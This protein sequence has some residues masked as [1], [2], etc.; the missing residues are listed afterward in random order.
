MDHQPDIEAALRYARLIIG[1]RCRNNRY[2]ERAVDLTT[3]AILAAARNFDPA[4]GSW[5]QLYGWVVNR[6]V[7][8]AISVEA[9][10]AAEEREAVSALA[11]SAE[12]DRGAVKLASPIEPEDGDGIW[13]KRQ[14]LTAKP[15]ENLWGPEDVESL[16]PPLRRAV[17]L[18]CHHG[19]SVV[20]TGLLCGGITPQ[21]TMHRLREAAKILGLAGSLLPS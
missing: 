21:A 13:L 7:N 2:R 10:R 5:P 17:L 14:P 19:Y 15:P 12:Q 11:D 16:P 8:R 18:H 1:R 20:E 6:A 3:D 9:R 4:V